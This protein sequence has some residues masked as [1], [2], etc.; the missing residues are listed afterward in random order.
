MGTK[1]Y[2]LKN[3]ICK[4]DGNYNKAILLC[5]HYDSRMNKKDDYTSRA[6]GANDNA[7]GVSAILET[8]RILYDVPT[9]YSIQF[10]LF[11][12][13]EQVL[14]IKILFRICQRKKYR[15]IQID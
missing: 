10:V 8:A 4:K 1:E 5:A 9:E 11:S 6:P 15:Y 14:G 2:N 13:E 7:S 12:G 3:I